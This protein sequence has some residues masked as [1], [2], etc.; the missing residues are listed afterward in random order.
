M[1]QLKSVNVQDTTAV[2]EINEMV[3]ELKFKQV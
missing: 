3:D 1:S 2:D